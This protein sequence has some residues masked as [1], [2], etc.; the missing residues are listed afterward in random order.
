[1][2]TSSSMLETVDLTLGYGREP[3]VTDI[4]V[5]VD[6]GATVC[7]I[8]PNGAGK[9]TVLKGIL[10][11]NRTFAGE[12]FVRGRSVTSLRAH[13]RVREG[14]GYV[15]QG[16]QVFADLRV[17]DNLRMGG[18]V[19]E[20]RQKLERRIQQ[21][22]ELFPRLDERKDQ[23]AGHLSG[24][25]QQMLAMARALVTSPSIVILDEPTL[26]LAPVA[27]GEVVKQLSRL[28]SVGVTT[29]MVEQNATL[30]LKLSDGAYVIDQ[31]TSGPYMSADAVLKDTDLRRL[32]LGG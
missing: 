23:L 28:R 26:G 8:G 19:V 13:E 15:P 30:A 21:L 27:V 4:N 7:I 29:L 11:F 2:A 20:D 6:E 12:V 18:F 22:L 17:V 1:M 9:S 32:Y 5:R 24:G 16:R 3:V 25:E 14:I 31:G 10:G